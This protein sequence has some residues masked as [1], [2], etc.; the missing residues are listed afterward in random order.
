MD[1]TIPKCI[2]R[3]FQCKYF[4]RYCR[5]R[6]HVGKFCLLS[7][8]CL[9]F[10]TIS[11]KV[12]VTQKWFSYHLKAGTKTFPTRGVTLLCDNYYALSNR[13]RNNF[14]NTLQKVFWLQA[15]LSNMHSSAA[16]SLEVLALERSD[17]TFWNCQIHSFNLVCVPYRSDQ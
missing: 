10:S 7:K 1:L 4:K 13:K 14:F 15:I 8:K 9:S 6:I 11:Q 17:Y 3:F 16:I 5:G 12:L 2:L